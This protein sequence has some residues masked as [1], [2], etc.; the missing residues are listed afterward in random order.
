MAA[1]ITAVRQMISIG[2]LRVGRSYLSSVVV[3]VIALI[4]AAARQDIAVKRI[5]KAGASDVLHLAR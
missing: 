2:R 3:S 1:P 4:G 5:G